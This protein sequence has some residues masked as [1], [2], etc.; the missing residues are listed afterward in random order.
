MDVAPNEVIVAKK[1]VKR[2]I[3]MR[4]L[5]NATAPSPPEIPRKSRPPIPRILSQALPNEP[6]K[7]TAEANGRD[8]KEDKDSNHNLFMFW[9][10]I[11][12]YIRLTASRY[13][14]LN[15]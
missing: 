2:N 4:I 12:E 10:I 15:E 14:H 9:R 6:G 11:W 7:I 8:N 5:V 1:A 3:Q 13:S